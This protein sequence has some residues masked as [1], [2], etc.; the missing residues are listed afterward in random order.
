[1]TVALCPL[2]KIQFFANTGLPLAGGYLYTSEPGL[3]GIPKDTYIDSLASAVNTNPIVLDAAGRASVWLNGYYA[4]ELWTGDKNLP[5]STLVWSQ[6][7]VSAAPASNTVVVV[8]PGGDPVVTNA[9][10]W[11]ICSEVPYFVN[12]TRFTVVGALSSTFPV[13]RRIQATVTGGTITGTITAVS[14]AGSPSV[15]TVTVAWDSGILDTGLSSISVSI[16]IPAATPIPIPPSV[17]STIDY[18][19]TNVDHGKR[20]QANGS[21]ALVFTLPAANTC[22]P[23]FSVN[24]KNIGIGVLTITGVVDGI[25]NPSLNQYEEKFLYTDGTS[26]Y[27]K[28]LLTPVYPEHPTI[29]GY[30]NLKITTIGNQAVNITADK[31]VMTDVQDFS[32]VRTSLSLNI[33]LDTVGYGGLDAGSLAA[34]TGYYLFAIDNGTTT[35][36][37]ASTSATAPVMPSGYTYKTLLGWCTTDATTTPFNIEEFVQLDDLYTWVVKPVFATVTSTTT[38]AVSLAAGGALTYALVPPNIAKAL[39]TRIYTLGG[40]ICHISGSS[41]TDSLAGANTEAELTAGP[42]GSL[43]YQGD[44]SLPTSQ[45][46][47]VQANGSPGGSYYAIGFILKR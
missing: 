24:I 3:L 19:I 34:N 36:G 43:N 32:K 1:M 23:G 45:T 30:K 18:V 41:F 9:T 38:A 39:R 16:L 13:G 40:N 44:V 33:Y 25:T 6:D 29:T 10:A 17:T 4:M 31:I 37:L 20:L 12:G 35:A 47:Y 26:W 42:T 28:T 11:S 21:I 5:G 27:G 46:V 2:P 14:V 15:T 7:N 8:D 22:A